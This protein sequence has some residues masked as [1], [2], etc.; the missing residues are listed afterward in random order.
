MNSGEVIGWD[1]LNISGGLDLTATSGNKFVIDLRTLTLSNTSGLIND[2]DSS[3]NY[4][5]TIARTV[6]G[7]TFGSGESES[8]L[9]QLLM[10]GFVN[11]LDGGTLAVALGNG[12]KDLNVTFTPAAV[13]EPSAMAIV[14]L[15]FAALLVSFRRKQPLPW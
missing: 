12:G 14:A 3:Q 10:G 2:F 7:I 6:T 9:F 13:P 5:W 1:M 8:T 15:G 11:S 4:I